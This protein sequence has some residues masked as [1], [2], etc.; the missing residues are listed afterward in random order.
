MALTA[1]VVGVVLF[2]AGF[3]GEMVQLNGP[4]RNDYLV[5]ETLN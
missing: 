3:L 4:K 1:V 5:R 2:V